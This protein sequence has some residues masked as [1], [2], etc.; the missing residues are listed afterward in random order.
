[1]KI[2]A[3]RFG[4]L[5]SKERLPWHNFADPHLCGDASPNNEPVWRVLDRARLINILQHTE[6][7]G[8]QRVSSII[9]FRGDD[10]LPQQIRR[11][12]GTSLA[13]AHSCL[14]TNVFDLCRAN[15]IL[16]EMPL[17]P[18]NRL[19]LAEAKFHFDELKSNGKS[20]FLSDVD[21]ISVVDTDP[22]D[23]IRMMRNRSLQALDSD[24]TELSESQW[25]FDLKTVITSKIRNKLN[26]HDSTSQLD[27][28]SRNQA[29]DPIYTRTLCLL[30]EILRNGR[31]PETS[32]SRTSVISNL[33]SS[34]L[35]KYHEK[36]SFTIV[37]PM[38]FNPSSK[39]GDVRLPLANELFP[40]LVDAVFELESSIIHQTLLGNRTTSSHCAVNCNAQFKPHVDSGRGAGQSV[41]MIVGLGNYVGGNLAVER[42]QYDIRYKPLEFDGWKSRHWTLP[43]MGERFSLVWFTPA[44]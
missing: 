12:V 34:D 41:S 36:G 3:G 15:D 27:D 19:Y 1:V 32:V 18:S 29:E 20:I 23:A 17:A 11:V 38:V 8:E 22:S 39:F 40:D 2:A 14:P 37:N 28:T 42:D 6:R 10:F 9:E 30:R 31:W 7:N 26:N 43:F 35:T 24:D 5:S 25:L 13:I 21:G 44:V 4:K 16:I 33:G